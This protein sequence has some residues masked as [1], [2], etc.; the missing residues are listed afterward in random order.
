MFA[1]LDRYNAREACKPRYYTGKRCRRGH[2][3]ERFTASGNCCQCSKERHQLLASNTWFTFRFQGPPN[4][5]FVSH[6]VA[7]AYLRAE[8]VKFY[9]S[10]GFF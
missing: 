5:K 6:D 1:M 2:D 4:W 8:F 3:A 10:Q 7:H 9:N